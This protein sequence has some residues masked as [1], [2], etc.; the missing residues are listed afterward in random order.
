MSSVDSAG[1]ASGSVIDKGLI[2]RHRQRRPGFL[3]RL[4]NAYLEEAPKYAR[5]VRASLPAGDWDGL[6][7]AAHTLKSSSANLGAER[8]SA[9]CLKL[10]QCAV[11]QNQA[12]CDEQLSR[13]NMEYFEVEQA[14]KVLLLELRNTAPVTA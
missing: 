6:K 8:L 10:E 3:E 2:A 5:A 14:L 1:A 11:A 4:I 7:M 13:F 9:V 12:D